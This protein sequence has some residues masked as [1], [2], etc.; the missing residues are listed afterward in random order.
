[1]ERELCGYCPFR[2]VQRPR[3]SEARAGQRF[4]GTW[5]G[6]SAS[7]KGH[8]SGLRPFG[9]P[10][11]LTL[12]S[13][14]LCWWLPRNLGLGGG[15]KGTGGAEGASGPLSWAQKGVTGQQR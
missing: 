6:P 12:F 5:G 10:L 3:R 7:E 9:H 11:S 13:V 1:M 15:P 2:C 8:T 14:H 4:I